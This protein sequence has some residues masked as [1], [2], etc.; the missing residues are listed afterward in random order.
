MS[1]LARPTPF[2]VMGG[3]AVEYAG[4]DAND[5]LRLWWTTAM[6]ELS[7]RAQL[8]SA[9]THS[10]ALADSKRSGEAGPRRSPPRPACSQPLC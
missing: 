5:D 10:G 6:S 8:A 3:V 1:L 7:G 2:P 4:A 9:M